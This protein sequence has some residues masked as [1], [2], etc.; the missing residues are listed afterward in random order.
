MGYDDDHVQ[1]PDLARLRYGGAAHHCTARVRYDGAAH[2]LL[3]PSKPVGQT[4][5]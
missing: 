3:L 4:T 1:G 2:H 5:S